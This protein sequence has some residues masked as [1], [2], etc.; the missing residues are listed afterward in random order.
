MPV[1]TKAALLSIFDLRVFEKRLFVIYTMTLLTGLSLTIY[2]YTLNLFYSS[3]STALFCVC[4]FLVMLL[5]RIGWITKTEY[6]FMFLLSAHLIISVLIE[7]AQSGQYFYYFPLLIG[8]PVVID[9][10]RSDYKVLLFNSAII[11]VSFVTCILLGV[12]IS[13][14][15]RFFLSCLVLET[16]A[17]LYLSFGGINLANKSGLLVFK[18]F[19]TKAPVEPESNIPLKIPF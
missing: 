4:L 16:P 19:V 10:E 5:K 7:G 17:H 15:E 3:T 1:F 8:I 18:P 9:Y 11:F 6:F 12:Y 14:L 2:Y 13:P